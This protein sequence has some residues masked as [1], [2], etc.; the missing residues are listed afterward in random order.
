VRPQC[1]AINLYPPKKAHEASTSSRLPIRCWCNERGTSAQKDSPSGRCRLFE[2]A[3]QIKGHGTPKLARKVL[4]DVWNLYGKVSGIGLENYY[5]DIE[6]RARISRF[7][8]SANKPKDWQKRQQNLEEL[9]RRVLIHTTC[10]SKAGHLE[11]VKSDAHK[12]ILNAVEKRDCLLTFNYDL[13]IEES[14][15]SVG[16]WTPLG[17]YGVWAHGV[18][19]AWCKNWLERRS[20][21]GESRSRVQLLKLHGS[22]NWRLYNTGQIRMKDRPFVVR[23]KNN[24]TV[25]ILPPG[26]DKRIDRNPYR[27]LWRQARLKLESCKTVVIIGYSLPEADLLAKALFAEVVRLPKARKSYIKQLHLADPN[28]LVKSKFVELFVPALNPHSKL[29]RYKDI[30]ELAAAVS[31]G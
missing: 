30:D 29:F 11:P 15:Q 12:K 24:E 31:A 3:G 4:S 26:W 18:R 8:K 16:V 9:I 10:R 6:T 17:G 19:G 14:F 13:L 1:L 7:A 21:T 2:I 5:R 20:L 25:S 22:L 27:K 23:T 28:D